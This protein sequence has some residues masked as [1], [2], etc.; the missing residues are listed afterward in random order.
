[1][2]LIPLQALE[3]STGTAPD[4]S[5]IWLHGLGA[6]G[7]DFAPIVN[8][9]R[10]PV[11]VRFVLPHAPIRSIT[12]NGGYRM[13]AWYD[14][15]SPEIAAIQDEAGIRASQKLIE[16]LIAQE[17][18]R[19]IAPQRILL[20]GFSQGGA[21]A[22]HTGLRYAKKLAGIIAL[23]TYL[24][25]DRTLLAEHS[26]TNA[27]IPIFMGHGR[28]DA[29]I[30]IEVAHASRDLLLSQHYAVIWHEY[31]MQHSVCAEEITDI[32]AFILHVLDHKGPGQ[33]KSS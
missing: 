18:R 20:V 31:T 2:Q 15:L 7:H 12:I 30:P 16:A 14:I 27:T 17:L 19:G 5:I 3:I 10:L 9:L 1:M 8:E 22:L 24:P 23:S 29:M 6:D 32:R 21:I 4:A 25:L 26:N 11:P 33:Q 28:Q 13:P